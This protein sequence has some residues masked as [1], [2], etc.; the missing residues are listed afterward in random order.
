MKIGGFAD[1]SGASPLALRERGMDVRVLLP[2]YSGVLKR[3]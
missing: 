3:L 1:A 2:A